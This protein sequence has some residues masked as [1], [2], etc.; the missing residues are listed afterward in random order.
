MATLIGCTVT[1][2]SA[3]SGGGIFNVHGVGIVILS[4]TK[5]KGN[6]GGDI[7]GL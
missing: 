3:A 6:T 7:V 1:G 5:V 4:G 2:N